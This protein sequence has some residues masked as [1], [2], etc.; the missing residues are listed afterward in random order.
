MAVELEALV[1]G[2]G[3][4]GLAAGRALARKFGSVCVV[5]RHRQFGFE[6]SSRN[7][8]VL[9][10]GIYYTPAS[11]KARLCREGLAALRGYVVEK[12]L[13]HRFCGKLIAARGAHGEAGLQTIKTLAESNGVVSLQWLSSAAARELE[14]DVACDMALLSPETGI[15]DSHALMAAY[16]A[17]IVE[18]GGVVACG[19]HVSRIVAEDG[20]FAVFVDG[21]ASPIRTLRIVNS[22]GLHAGSVARMV[23]G[24]DPGSAP[25]HRYARGVYFSLQGGRQPFR[26]LVYPLPD[27]ASLGIHATIDL[28]G[29]VRFG[30]DVEWIDDPEDYR[31]DPDREQVFRASIAT[32]FPGIADRGLLPAYAGIRPKLA[33]PGEPA[34]D[35]RIDHADRHG[36]P[37]L[38]NLYG[39]E[40]PGLTAS[41]AI[42]RVVAD[43]FS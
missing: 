37:G 24:L 35:F 6:T 42:A 38:C 9:H 11:L 23:E 8:E 5:E 13:P 16:E 15:I 28:A 39:I 34:A 17:D 2:A 32:Y 29:Q 14:P 12:R 40:S 31:V 26:R 1:I 27:T 22:G 10:A 3:V 43:G 4:V 30:P 19:N 18:A 7:S 33:G 41:L 36:L 21:E 25:Q 20:G